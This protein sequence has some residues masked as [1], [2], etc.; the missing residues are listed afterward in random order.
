MAAE[1]LGG[2]GEVPHGQLAQFEARYR[3]FFHPVRYT[4]LGLAVCEAMMVGLPIVGLATTEL[5]TVVENG[6]TGFISTNV[7]ELIDRM[8]QLIADPQL[9]HRLSRAAREQAQARFGID[10]F[11]RDWNLA[12]DRVVS[13]CLVSR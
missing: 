9:A 8:Q 2:L 12:F 5:A 10:R 1:S 13:H 3:F 4:S 11:I 6:R 7:E